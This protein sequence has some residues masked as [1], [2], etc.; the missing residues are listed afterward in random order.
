MAALL[1]RY[2]QNVTCTL[3]ALKSRPKNKINNKRN[4]RKNGLPNDYSGRTGN[5]RPGEPFFARPE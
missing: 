2:L 5:E 4:K 1:L 3:I